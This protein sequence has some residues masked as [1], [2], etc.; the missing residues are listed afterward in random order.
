MIKG[1]V[2]YGARHTEYGTV[3]NIK[4]KYQY[5]YRDK[6]AVKAEGRCLAGVLRLLFAQGTGHKAVGTDTE[7]VG[8]HGKTHK[9]G[10]AYRQRRDL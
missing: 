1:R 9:Y 8:H 7:K 10:E 6:R 5:S 3:K 2:G 4:Y